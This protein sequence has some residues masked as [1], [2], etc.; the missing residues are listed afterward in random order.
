[1]IS[2]TIEVR[3]SPLPASLRL[4][5]WVNKLW[6][7]PLLD[8]V[9]LT[10]REKAQSSYDHMMDYIQ[11]RW[12]DCINRNTFFGARMMGGDVWIANNNSDHDLFL[13]GVD[14]VSVQNLYD[15]IL[16]RRSVLNHLRRRFDMDIFGLNQAITVNDLQEMIKTGNAV[17]LLVTPDRLIL[18]NTELAQMTRFGIIQCLA[19]M[20][21]EQRIAFWDDPNSPV[22]KLFRQYYRDWY[23]VPRDDDRVR[24]FDPK[25]IF[26]ERLRQY[27]ERKS[28]TTH[29][30]SEE[31][32]G[33]FLILLAQFKLPDFVTYHQAMVEKQGAL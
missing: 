32:I 9:T 12:G 25:A 26:E 1:M 23:T 24:N 19:D 10:H 16:D 14:E 13:Y 6:Q 33:R 4:R 3:M 15:L 20:T 22:Q 30:E 7:H 2:Q 27:A 5:Q 11:E 18:G 28:L 17:S 8:V 21:D 31:F 29:L